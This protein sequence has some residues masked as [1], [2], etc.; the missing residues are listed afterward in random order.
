[1]LFFPVDNHTLTNSIYNGT[2]SESLAKL[3][4][5]AALATILF[6]EADFREHKL[7]SLCKHKP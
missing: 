2:V 4:V 3:R 7:T 1:M 5:I 6:D